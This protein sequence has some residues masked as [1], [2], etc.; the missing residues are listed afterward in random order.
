[1]EKVQFMVNPKDSGRE[2]IWRVRLMGK[3]NC[4]G[5]EL[6]LIKYLI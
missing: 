2:E 3:V 5:R 1:M 6:R 4:V